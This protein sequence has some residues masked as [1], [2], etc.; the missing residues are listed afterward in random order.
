MFNLKTEVERLKLLE[1]TRTHGQPYIPKQQNPPIEHT[2]GSVLDT[3]AEREANAISKS[4]K[5]Y[6]TDFG[7]RL[8]KA[9]GEKH[10]PGGGV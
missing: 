8:S 4:F 2:D 1:H 9:K 5:N 7:L 3:D 6:S 10:H